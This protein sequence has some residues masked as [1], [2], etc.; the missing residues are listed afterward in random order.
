MVDTSIKKVMAQHSP[1]GPMGQK[2]LV[3]G[4]GLAMRLWEDLPVGPSP[5]SSARDYETIGY[6]LK[7]RAE[8]QIEGQTIL[9]DVGDSWIVPKGASHSYTILDPFTAIE[10]THPP[11]HIHGRDEV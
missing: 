2:Y 11:A 1:R 5:H 8:L 10:A 4:I 3:S 7:G 9:L 6:V